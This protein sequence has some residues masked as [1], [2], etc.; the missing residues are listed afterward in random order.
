MNVGIIDK[1]T[2]HINLTDIDV[3][4]ELG[5]RDG[6]YTK[7]LLNFYNPKMIYSIDCNP[8]V[9]EEIINNI[10]N[11]KNVK[12]YPIALSDSEGFLDFFVHPDPGSSSLYKHPINPTV[13]ISVKSTTLDNFCEEQKIDKIDLI[14]ADVE[15]AEARIFKNQKI[16]NTVKYIISEVKFDD[17]FK[18]KDFPNINHL[19]D[20][21][22]PFGFKLIETHVTPGFPFGDS[23]WIKN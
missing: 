2:K 5:C 7:E 22:E 17:D 15:G 12:F 16:L 1:F 19:K 9:Q 21:L 6:L 20:S 3:I 10:K 4:L 14:M 8:F 23:L 13:K 18:G 11:L